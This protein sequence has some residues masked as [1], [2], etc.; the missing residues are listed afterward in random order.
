MSSDYKEL[1]RMIEK[2]GELLE[3][4]TRTL[5]KLKRYQT[6]A[7][8]S[9]LLWYALLIGLPFA[10]YYYV[11]APVIEAYGFHAN[12]RELPGYGQF[13]AFFGKMGEGE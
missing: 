9:S 4:N 12:L 5:N 8:F 11:L 3:D 1:K 2:Q 13:E 6:M 7:F 10:M